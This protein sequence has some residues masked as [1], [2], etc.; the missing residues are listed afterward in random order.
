M[1][2]AAKTVPQCA[3]GPRSWRQAASHHRMAL[4]KA[5]WRETVLVLFQEVVGDDAGGFNDAF[6]F[7]AHDQ[8]QKLGHA[9]RKRRG[10]SGAAT[11]YK[12]R[13]CRI[14]LIPDLLRNHAALIG[15]L[16]HRG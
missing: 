16:Q 5:S 11:K 6:F 12:A 8:A 2:P 3:V 10:A 4:Q 9:P 1:Q 7:G 14:G 15:E 13:T